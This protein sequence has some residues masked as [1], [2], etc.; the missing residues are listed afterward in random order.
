[1]LLLLFSAP[2]VGT[3]VT[4]ALTGV[5]GVTTNGV[6]VASGSTLASSGLASG[7]PGD[8]VG[9]FTPSTTVSTTSTALTGAVGTFGAP[10]TRAITGVL[11]T[12]SPGFV[13]ASI[14]GT[15]TLTGVGATG[16]AGSVATANPA[17]VAITGNAATGSPGS[18]GRA[19][20]NPMTSAGASATGATGSFGVSVSGFTITTVLGTGSVGSVGTQKAVALTG[21]TAAGSAGTLTLTHA[22]AITTTLGTG[23]A[24]VVAGSKSGTASISG[25]GATTAIG[26][27]RV[28]D[29]EIVLSS[30]ALVGDVGFVTSSGGDPFPATDLTEVFGENRFIVGS[31]FSVF[32]V[33]P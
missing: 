14:S 15:S 17:L 20:A 5:E 9:S 26:T 6:N 28:G 31:E 10:V 22:Q 11:G 21:P 7:G 32:V 13:T 2:V 18:V 8:G 24:G 30:D 25:V 33:L 1:M 3:P 19:H 12:G 27:V 16:S 29:R 23:A 4:V